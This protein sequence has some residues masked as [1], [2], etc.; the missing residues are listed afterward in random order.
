MAAHH[1]LFFFSPQLWSPFC[2][3]CL[4]PVES[5]IDVHVNPINLSLVDGLKQTKCLFRFDFLNYS[6]SLGSPLSHNKGM[7]QPI[8]V[9]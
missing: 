5:K 4:D 9:E 6:H 3:L 1:P 8:I 2:R 7:E